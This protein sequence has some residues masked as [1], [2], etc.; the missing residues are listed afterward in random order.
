MSKHD[1]F[2]VIQL[3]EK[4][5]I[6]IPFKIHKVLISLLAMNTITLL[7]DHKK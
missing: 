4:V 6:N 7:Q 3:I 1:I 2:N 5:C